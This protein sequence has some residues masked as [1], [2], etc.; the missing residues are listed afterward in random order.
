MIGGSTAKL[1]DADAVTLD[2]ENYIGM[3]SDCPALT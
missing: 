2:S 1:A 3:V